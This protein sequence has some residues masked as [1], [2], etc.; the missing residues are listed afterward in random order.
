MRGT[1]ATLKRCNDSRPRSFFQILCHQ[2]FRAARLHKVIDFIESVPDQ[3]QPEAAGLDQ[4]M[5]PPLHRGRR[6]LFAVIAQPHPNT[7]P[8]AFEGKR[9]QLV[10]AQMIGVPNNV[11]AGFVYTQHHE[12]PFLLGE[13]VRIEKTTHEFSHRS[14][15]ARVAGELDFLFF[16]QT[17]KPEPRPMTQFRNRELGGQV[18]QP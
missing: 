14:D 17:R 11:R 4:I 13:R 7:I 1:A 8:Q 15:I 16:H 6:C 12:R 5:R 10:V 2:E 9:N 18:E 3:V